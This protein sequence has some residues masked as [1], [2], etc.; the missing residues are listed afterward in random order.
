M[1]PCKTGDQ[2]YS[3][4]SPMVSVLWLNAIAIKRNKNNNFEIILGEWRFA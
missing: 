3:E 1:Q 2:P 4:P